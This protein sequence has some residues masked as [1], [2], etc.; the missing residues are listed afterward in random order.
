VTPVRVIVI[1]AMV[2]I[3]IM[4]VT[5]IVGMRGRLA[6]PPRGA[7]RAPARNF[8][9]EI[10]RGERTAL[11]LSHDQAV[12]QPQPGEV[13]LELLARQTQVE[14]RAEEHV[15]GDAGEAV[16]MQD[17][18]ARRGGRRPLVPRAG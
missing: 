7:L 6:G 2:V 16:E 11:N 1:V 13:R 15:P 4:I 9:V 3:V 17:A 14:Q 5:V 12:R 10:A 8:D 18:R